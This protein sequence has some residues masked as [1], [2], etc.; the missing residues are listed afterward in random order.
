MGR[1]VLRLILVRYN[2]NFENFSHAPSVVEAIKSELIILE[3]NF[4]DEIWRYL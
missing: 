3:M 4:G 1:L 2:E